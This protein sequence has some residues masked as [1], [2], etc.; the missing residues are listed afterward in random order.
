MKVF[1]TKCGKRWHI[2]KQFLPRHVLGLCEM[3]EPLRD[4]RLRDRS[5]VEEEKICKF[6]LKEE[7]R[8]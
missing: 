1:K 3:Y 7:G 6:C 8:E 2:V 5:E 4:A